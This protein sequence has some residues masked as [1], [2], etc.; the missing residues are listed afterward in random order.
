MSFEVRAKHLRTVLSRL[1]GEALEGKQIPQ[2]NLTQRKCKCA[3][4]SMKSLLLSRAVEV[5]QFICVLKQQAKNHETDTPRNPRYS[6]RT[7]VTYNNNNKLL[8]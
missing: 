8:F 7:S 3:V 5:A 6:R 2:S 1:H 4:K